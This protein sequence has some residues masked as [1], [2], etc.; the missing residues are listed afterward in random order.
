MVSQLKH[1]NEI[2]SNGQLFAPDNFV[3]VSEM[4]RSYQK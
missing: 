2:L 3:E 1:S 4:A